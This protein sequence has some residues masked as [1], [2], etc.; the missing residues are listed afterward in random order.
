MV[1]ITVVTTSVVMVVFGLVVGSL[2]TNGLIRGKEDAAKATVDKSTQEAV[3]LLNGQIS[4]LRDP[5]AIP[6]IASVV[7]T[8]SKADG[9]KVAILPEPAESLPADEQ[10]V[11]PHQGLPIASAR[12]C[13]RT[14]LSRS[15]LNSTSVTDPSSTWSTAA[16][17][18]RAGGRSRPSTS[19]R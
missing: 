3:N 19:S 16:N 11:I 8:L 12:P 15:G 13:A 5:L 4:G 14:G 1:T 2:I 10:L 9:V 7:N 17:S 6:N 18:N